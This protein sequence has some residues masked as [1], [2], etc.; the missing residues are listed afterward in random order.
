MKGVTYKPSDGALTNVDF[1][2]DYPRETG[3]NISTLV[4]S[5]WGLAVAGLLFCCNGEGVE[6]STVNF[7]PE[8]QATSGEDRGFCVEHSVP[9][10]KAAAAVLAFFHHHWHLV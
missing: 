10:W 7:L 4:M 2:V 6:G 3:L 5:R 1:C 9:P 8:M